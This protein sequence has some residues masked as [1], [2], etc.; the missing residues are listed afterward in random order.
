MVA[1]AAIPATTRPSLAAPSSFEALAELVTEDAI[2]KQVVRATRSSIS[3]R[4][5]AYLDAGFDHVYLHQVGPDQEGFS[6]SEAE[7]L[8]RCAAA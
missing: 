6:G 5:Q 2:A 4:I 1:T 8:P 3:R 7:L